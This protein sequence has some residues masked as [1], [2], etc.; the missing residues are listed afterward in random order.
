MKIYNLVWNL[1]SLFYICSHKNYYFL[2]TFWNIL[3][4]LIFVNFTALPSIA[5]VFGF[6][7][8]QTNVIISEEETHS[9]S[10]F[11]VYEKTIPKTL[12]VHDFIKFFENYSSENTFLLAD[13]SI[14]LSP[15]L[16]IFS[17]PPEA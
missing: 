11:I 3:V 7:L 8:P 2:K 10:S 6:E 17:P 9:S 1:I 5:T 14:H 12:N 4:L 15:Y 16:S 13:D